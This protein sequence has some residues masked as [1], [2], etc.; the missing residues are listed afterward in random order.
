MYLRQLHTSNLKRLR[1]F[2]LDFTHEGKPRMWTVLMGENGTAKT[3]ILQAIALAAAG[4]RQVNTLA[5]PVAR[6]LRDRR[7]PDQKLTIKA[8]FEFGPRAHGKHVHPLRPGAKRLR[9]RSEL[10]LASSSLSLGG[11]AT[12]LQDDK[13]VKTTDDP[14]DQARGENR[15]VWFVAGYG[16]ARALPDAA[17]T[18]T[19]DFPSIDRLSPLFDARAPLASTSFSNHF[20]KKDLEE[21]REAGGTSR[22]YA[23]ILKDVLKAGG[24][25]LLPGIMDF[26]LRGR[27]GAKNAPDLVESDRFYQAMGTGRMAVAG[28]ALSHGFQS[29][30]AWIA[31]LVGH[32]LL[33]SKT[34]LAPADIEGLVLLDE[35]D[36]YLH[37]QWQATIITALRRIFPRVQFVVTTHSPVVLASCAPHEVVRLVVDPETGDV[38]RGAWDPE[39]GELVGTIAREPAQPDP[40]VMTGNELYRTWFGLDRS[41]PNPFGSD[42]RRYTVLAND[43][44]RSKEEQAEL[45]Q[46]GKALAAAG[47]TDLPPVARKGKNRAGAS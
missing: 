46:A 28:V 45:E 17:S 15:H 35:I 3:S 22:M 33:E 43:P 39:T 27:G 44:E 25:D 4:S 7:H 1:E 21:S 10:S 36:L 32:V 13:P 2:K 14:L 8:E 26:E 23:R 24:A 20:A 30:F 34:E 40:R 11:A 9:L 19:L 41:T 18:P 6:H 37:P 12:Y 16:I 29:T 31:D 47:V 38:Q 42:L 5:K